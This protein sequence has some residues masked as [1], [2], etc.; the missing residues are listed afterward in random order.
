MLHS[1]IYNW[2]PDPLDGRDHVYRA[3]VLAPEIPNTIDLHALMSKVE[4]QGNLGSCTANGGVS[5]YEYLD[6]R[7]DHRYLNRSRL[8][9][10]WWSRFIDGTAGWD[11]GA[12]IR[13]TLKAMLNYGICTETSW[14]YNIAK[15]RLKPPPAQ[16]RAAEKKK[17]LEYARV[18]QTE[19]AIC[20]AL[21]EGY[22]VIFG[23]AVYDSFESERVKRTGIMPMP[24]LH[25]ETLLGGHCVTAVGYDLNGSL[26]GLKYPVVMCRNSWGSAWGRKGYFLMPMEFILNDNLCEDFWVVSKVAGVK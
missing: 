2:A 19:V 1:R 7:Y 12:Y 6:F 25:D 4:D 11:S 13:D 20:S 22:P 16:I 24:N 9:L 3:K 5:L 15:F 10:Y 8:F 26:W 18:D 17:A 14:P 23:F 21:A